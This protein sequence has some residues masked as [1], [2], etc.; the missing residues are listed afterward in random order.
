MGRSDKV[1]FLFSDFLYDLLHPALRVRHALIRHALCD[2]WPGI[3]PVATHFG[4]SHGVY[5]VLGRAMPNTISYRIMLRV[6]HTNP[7]HTLRYQT[8]PYCTIPYTYHTIP[9]HTICL[10]VCRWQ[11]IE[12]KLDDHFPLVVFQTG[13]GTQTN[14]NCNEVISNR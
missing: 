7:Y 14:M 9:Y 2:R 11:V 6:F 3:P 8:I 10:A 13:S 5:S 12:G 4:R 1:G